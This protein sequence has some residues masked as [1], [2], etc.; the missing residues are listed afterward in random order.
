MGFWDDKKD[1]PENF[2]TKD[3]IKELN[4]KL[5]KLMKKEQPENAMGTAKK[6][7]GGISRG[8][9]NVAKSLNTPNS[10]RRMKIG[11]MPDR[12]PPIARTRPQNP[13]AG[14]NAGM[15]KHRISDAPLD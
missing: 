7:I 13:V 4:K 12:K 14:R 1:K 8:I 6:V 3:D 9:N 10:G 15:K 2:A 5:E 11:Q